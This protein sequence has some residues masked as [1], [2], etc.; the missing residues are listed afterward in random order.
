MP[1]ADQIYLLA[2]LIFASI[3]GV[4]IRMTLSMVNQK[5]VRT[6]HNTITYTLLPAVAFVITKVISGNIALSLGMIGALSIIRF[7][8]PVRSSLELVIFF[9]L[10]TIGIAFAVNNKWAAVLVFFIIFVLIFFFIL[11]KYFV[12]NKKK[13]LFQLSFDEGNYG[14]IIEISL[15]NKLDFDQDENLIHYNYSETLNLHNYKFQFNDRQSL[16]KF[17][18]KLENSH[19]LKNI[20]VQYKF[21]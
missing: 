7:R 16:I 17:K 18:N 14:N 4:L 15:Q 13:P 19:D 20:D 6:Y 21:N 12:K 11:E 8:N 9:A 10:M 3:G 5:W 2:D 1:S